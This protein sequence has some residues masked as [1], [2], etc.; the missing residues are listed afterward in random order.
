[1][2]GAAGAEASLPGS[3][4]RGEASGAWSVTIGPGEAALSGADVRGVAT[5]AEALPLPPAA[6]RAARCPHRPVPFGNLPSSI[7]VR[8][9]T[10][11][12]ILCAPDSGWV[13][14]GHHLLLVGPPG[15]RQDHARPSSLPGV[16]P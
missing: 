5:L 1:M 6:T 4:P 7:W 11:T 10:D 14:G 16:L 3:W 13:A 9:A 12:G 2:G 8:C 15:C